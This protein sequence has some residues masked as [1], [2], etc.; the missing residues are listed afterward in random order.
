MI[1]NARVKYSDCQCIMFRT[2]GGMLRPIKGGGS[3]RDICVLLSESV[4][5]V[6]QGGRRR[7]GMIGRYNPKGKQPTR[8]FVSTD[9]GMWS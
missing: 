7:N 8:N 3:G 4:V 9:G 6:E 1:I 5:V 2:V